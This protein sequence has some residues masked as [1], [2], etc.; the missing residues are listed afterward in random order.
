[1]KPIRSTVAALLLLAALTSCGEASSTPSTTEP[2]R[3]LPTATTSAD[4]TAAQTTQAP[5]APVDPN[6]SS[7]YELTYMD[8]IPDPIS[9]SYR[10][11]HLRWR[12]G[13]GTKRDF[14]VVSRIYNGTGKP[15]VVSGATLSIKAGN[16]SAHNIN[17][18]ITPYY[19][20]PYQT[21]YAVLEAGTRIDSSIDLE[22]VDYS[23][24][25]TT[26]VAK[27]APVQYYAESALATVEH[28]GSYILGVQL[29]IVMRDPP[30]TRFV[31]ANVVLYNESG[32]AVDT[33]SRKLTQRDGII[34]LTY[35]PDMNLTPEDI[36]SFSFTLTSQC[37]E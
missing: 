5:I 4:E 31:Q 12:T 20:M 28:R 6:A 16:V 13:D 37:S 35:T 11:E 10:T 8:R 30:A 36:S 23:F 3:T 22:E 2:P 1:M 9:P 21:G 25:V 24:A 33:F 19:L 17:Q 15:I 32:I 18:K 7:F 29:D 27:N 14:T 34:T 26:K